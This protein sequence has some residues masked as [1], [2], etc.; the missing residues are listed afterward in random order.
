MITEKISYTTSQGE[1]FNTRE[2]AEV[3]EATY[4]Q[5]KQIEDF[6]KIH[7]PPNS[8]G[9]ASPATAIAARAIA[10]WEAAKLK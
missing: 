1:K 7:F 4:G 3:A 10:T 5:R 9:R 2:E 6:C 8:S